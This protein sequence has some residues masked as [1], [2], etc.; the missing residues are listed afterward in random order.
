[1]KHQMQRFTFTLTLLLLL[2]SPLIAAAA[3]RHTGIQGQASLTISYGVGVEV[4]PGVWVAP[5][6]VSLPVVASFTVLSARTGQQVAQVTTDQNGAYRLSL[7]P[8]KYVLV[9]EDITI[10]SGCSFALDPIEVTVY[11]R[12]FAPANLYYFRLGPCSIQAGP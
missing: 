5:P 9:P 11:P 4:A 6:S 7:P 12:R 8:G 10:I 2:T 3:P 1:M